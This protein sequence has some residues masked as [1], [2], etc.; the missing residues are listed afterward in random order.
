MMRTLNDTIAELRVAVTRLKH[1]HDALL[2]AAQRIV[3]WDTDD[4]LRLSQDSGHGS[5]YDDAGE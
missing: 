4:R 2:A 1:D 3:T 5:N